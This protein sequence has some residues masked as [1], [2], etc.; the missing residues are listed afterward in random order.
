MLAVPT[1]AQAAEAQEPD[2]DLDQA[3]H[4]YLQ[5]ETPLIAAAHGGLFGFVSVQLNAWYPELDGDIKTGTKTQAIKESEFVVLPVVTFN[6]SKFGGRIDGFTSKF[7]APTSE[8][9][10]DQIRALFL[11]SFLNTR[12]LSL[13]AEAGLIATLVDVTI[14]GTSSSEDFVLP[15]LGLLFE[16]KVLMFMFEVE[17]TGATLGSG[18]TVVDFRAAAAWAILKFGALRVGYR[19]IYMDLDS[20]GT[21]LS[22]ANLGGFFVGIGFQF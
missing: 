10:I 12:T 22:S 17:L 2:A 7:T 3:I 21:A 20:N 8:V 11:W 18:E 16:A 15:A 5:G 1:T 9:K 6:I 19:Q 13:T 4:G 14:T